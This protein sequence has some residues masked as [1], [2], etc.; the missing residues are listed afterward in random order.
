MGVIYSFP[1]NP[2]ELRQNHWLQ[3]LHHKV[4]SSN[5]ISFIETIDVG[6]SHLVVLMLEALILS[7]S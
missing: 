3:H 7:C 5:I 6:A 4:T 1:E 2:E